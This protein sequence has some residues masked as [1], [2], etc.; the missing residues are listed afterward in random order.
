MN[1]SYWVIT[2]SLLISRS[3]LM[4]LL[5]T[6]PVA[7]QAQFTLRTNINQISVLR[8]TG[9]ANE[10]IIPN[11]INGLPVTI[12]EDGAFAGCTGLK[13]VTI[14]N[15]VTRIGFGAFAACTDLMSI[16]IPT[17]VTTIGDSAF[18]GCSKLTSLTI[19]D[20]AGSI[21]GP[22]DGCTSL[23]NV[24][25]PKYVS[26]IGYRTFS[27]C[28]VLKSINVDAA[29]ES[30]SSKDGVL[31]NKSQ[32]VLLACPP[33]RTA[34][35]II[36]NSVT[37][38]GESS[39]YRC[40]KLTSIT[41]PKSVN[42][43][44]HE[45]FQWCAGLTSLNIPT[46]VTEIGNFVFSFCTGLTSFTIPN[47]LTNLSG[48]DLAGCT[49][50]KSINVDPSHSVYRS[51]DGVLFDKNQGILISYPA[52]R[53]GAYTIPNGVNAIGSYAFGGCKNLTAVTIP[54]SITKIGYGG[55]IFCVGLTGVSIPESV[56]TIGE[57]AFVGCIGLKDILIPDSVTKIGL[58]AFAGCT[59]LKA[60]N[61]DPVNAV[62]SSMD[63]V[64]FQKSETSLVSYPGGGSSSYTIP[65]SVNSIESYAFSGCSNLTAITIHGG[66]NG[67][68]SGTFSGCASLKNIVIPNGVIEIG[69][70]AFESC[71]SLT[72]I[73]L[74]DGV[75]SM[76][77][78]SFRDCI[79]LTSITIPKSVTTIMPRAFS[80]C[81]SLISVHF[82]GN[83]L[84][85]TFR[86]FFLANQL[87]VYFDSGT[88]GWTDTYAGRPTKLWNP[89]TSV[90][91]PSIVAQPQPL[92]VSPGQGAT[93][94]VVATGTEPLS[95]AWQKNGV[96]LAGA[97]ASTLTINN[98]QTAD[99]GGYS[100]RVSNAAGSATSAVA[101]L[102]VGDAPIAS[103]A[104][105]FAVVRG[106]LVASVTIMDGGNGYTTEPTVTLIGGGGLGATAK[107]FIENGRVVEVVVLSSGSGYTTSPA[108]QISPPPIE[109]LSLSLR[110][111]AAVP[112]DG[113]NPV[114][115]ILEWAPGPDG[116]WT[117]WTNGVVAPGQT[118]RIDFEGKGRLF[119]MRPPSGSRT[120]VAEAS[121]RGGFVSSVTVKDTGAGYLTPPLV[122]LAGGGGT[123]ATAVAILDGDK[124]GWVVMVQAGSGYTTA[125][126]VVLGSPPDGLSLQHRWVPALKVSGPRQQGSRLEVGDSIFGPWRSWT[127]GVPDPS[128]TVLVDLATGSK[129][130]FY[131]AAGE[132]KP[133]GT[134]G[135]VWIQP[136]I[137]VMG[138]PM[139][140]P[141][142]WD[143]ETHHT[144]TLTQG[145]WLSDHEVTQAEYQAVMGNN[146]SSF[147][148][149]VLLPVEQVSWDDAV[150][151]CQKLTD[152]ERAT[153]RITAQQAYRLPTEAEWEYAARAGTI[154]ALYGE[155]DAIAWWAGN[156]GWDTHVVKQKLPNAWGLY[157]MIGNVWEWC[158]DWYDNY[159][160]GT[161]TDPVGPSSGSN[162][163]IRGGG[164]DG[165]AGFARSAYRG[166]F[167]PG[168][169]NYFLGFRPALS[170]V[171]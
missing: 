75:T 130:V 118:E 56:I 1:P 97:T 120:A 74:P 154:G 91:A 145:F 31:F 52:G 129:S 50:L 94:T 59:G 115:W 159:P 141:D 148:G 49:G 165:V 64:L 58:A 25:I 153:G 128:G 13:S 164:W 70:N 81:T 149:D 18:Y 23:T 30:L 38:I 21:G 69:Q 82:L 87:T 53:I 68:K 151:Y 66:I 125:P 16:K 19:P 119:R 36:P 41:I 37:S 22:F 7:V 112:I 39:F 14:P 78:S 71:A 138:S 147:K 142:R 157:D 34:G 168:G 10:L 113:T 114:D 160:S 48:L 171:R 144:V 143:D 92:T 84:E 73:V 40:D 62:Y 126:K 79:S 83:A 29:N 101:Q 86:D 45:A 105:A 136:G 96:N 107:A 9:S 121:I 32:T 6:L 110:M 2:F 116:P 57:G 161:V 111:V 89:P 146:P 93:F 65:S 95:Y 77:S 28:T 11:A 5:L 106:G 117:V 162:R 55:F 27:G 60:I 80:G 104:T 139:S 44:E 98:V 72:N 137:F 12:I 76:G 99:A 134:E 123:G 4:G 47:S 43:I 163:V 54:N 42:K 127:T 33:G 150:L 67:I 51:V 46:S 26:G 17:G 24:N 88:T 152:R 166:G 90:V 85:N 103:A 63:G 155:L 135:F 8:Y 170:S 20:G 140:E 15:S 132:M 169:R 35:Y 133:V 109:P 158:G 108:V 100:V 61:V 122:T 3:F 131:R 167:V 124:V 156:S 102:T